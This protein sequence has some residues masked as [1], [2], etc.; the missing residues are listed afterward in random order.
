MKD[1]R[2]KRCLVTGAASGIGRATAFAL[3][4]EGA[5]LVLTDIDEPG[6]DAV[7]AALAGSVDHAEALDLTDFDRVRAFA[8]AVHAA[9]GPVDVVLN[10][11]GISSW[12]AI[13]TVDHAHWRRLVEVNLMGPVHVL[14]CFV[15]EMVRAGRGGH[16]VNVSSAAGL[17]GLPW[18]AAYSATKFGL[19]GISE[20]LRFDLRRHRI[21]VT[22]VCPGAVDTPLVQTVDIVGIDREHP[23]AVKMA[24]AFR[25]HAASPDDVAAKIVDAIKKRRALVYTS[26]DIQAAFLLQRYVPPAY[27]F[28]MQ[29]LNDRMVRVADKARLP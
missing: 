22:L 11:A 6:L 28:V 1:L 25:K 13:E 27:S 5:R 8:D 20:V 19:R 26:R 16:I 29:R 4:A 15:P 23:A 17:L 18:H 21:G 7:V 14:E 10:V 9:G 2:G 12:G 24:A 3:Q